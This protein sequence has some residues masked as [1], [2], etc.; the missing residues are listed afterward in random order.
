M[1]VELRL[2]L[3][4]QLP[5]EKQVCGGQLEF[6]QVRGGIGRLR[7]YCFLGTDGITGPALTAHIYSPEFI[8]SH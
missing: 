1:F 3:D 7:N 6:V 4:P 2:Y 8:E 5:Q